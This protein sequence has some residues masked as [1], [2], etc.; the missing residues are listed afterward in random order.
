MSHGPN[1]SL[2]SPT[3]TWENE[4]IPG[5]LRGMSLPN[6]PLTCFDLC[7]T[8]RA[9]KPSCIQQRALETVITPS[10]GD[11]MFLTW[12][13]LLVP[14]PMISSLDYLQKRLYK[15][16]LTNLLVPRHCEWLS[17]WDLREAFDWLQRSAHSKQPPAGL[18]NVA[19]QKKLPTHDRLSKII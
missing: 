9:V 14:R 11:F 10:G 5:C 18:H 15:R 17:S 2:V 1:G 7:P 3:R 6:A 4:C 13:R 16:P 19:W 12:W 8:H